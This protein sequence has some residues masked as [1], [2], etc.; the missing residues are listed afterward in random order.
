MKPNTFITILFL[1][2]MSAVMAKGQCPTATAGGSSTICELDA[3]TVSGATAADGTISWTHNGD[4][5]LSGGT[6]LTPAY[7]SVAADAGKTITL[8]LTVSKGGCADAIA[9][10]TVNV[11][12]KPSAT[13]G[14]TQTICVMGSATVSGATSGNGSIMW[15]EN[16]DGTLTGETTL[17]P[18]YTSVASDAGKTVVLTMTVSNSPCPAATATYSVIVIGT[19]S[20]SAGGSTTICE[21]GTATVSGASAANGAILW[22]EDGYGSLFGQTTLTPVYTPAAGDAGKTVT[23]TMTVSNG[24]CT[25]ATASYS[26]AV[27]AAPV[28]TAGGITAI[29]EGGTATVSGATASNG[30]ILWGTSGAGTLTG[31]TT[32]SPSYTPA[33]GESAVTLTMTVTNAYCSSASADF[34]INVHPLPALAAVSMAGHVCD[35]SKGTVQLTGLLSNS[36]FT[37]N[38]SYSDH[39]NQTAV[40]TT[41]AGETSKS[42]LTSVNLD[43]G[44]DNGDDLIINSLTITSSIPACSMNF[45]SPTYVATLQVDEIPTLGTIDLDS[46]VCEGSSATVTLNGMLP[47]V[48]SIVRYTI[49]GTVYEHSVTAPGGSITFE[50]EP[51]LSE[52]NGGEFYITQVKT[53]T[54]AQCYRDYTT[55]KYHSITVNSLPAP[56]VSGP[57]TACA[58]SAGNSYST[59]SSMTNYSWEITGGTITSAKDIRNITV[60]WGAGATGTLAVSTT[61]NSC[62]GTSPVHS[63]TLNAN[64]G[65]IISGNTSACLNSTGN[66]YSIQNGM[67]SYS[68]S[69]SAGGTITSATDGSSIAVTWN[70]AGA[71]TVSVNYT[72]PTGCSATQVHNVMVNALPVPAI[73]PSV[74]V[75]RIND[76]VTY[77]TGGNSTW[78]WLVSSGGSGTSSTNTININWNSTGPQTV[79]VN[80]LDANNC[81]ATL[82]TKLDVDVKPLPSVSGLTVSYTYPSAGTTMEAVYTY[83]DGVS[84]T[85][86]CTGCT[87]QWFSDA[88]TIPGATAKTYIP[89]LTD[90][91]KTLTVRVTPVSTVG[92]SPPYTGSSVISSPTEIIEDLSAGVPVASQ[93]CIEGIRQEGSLL[94]GKYIYTHVMPEGHSLYK[95]I[96]TDMTEPTLP[97]VTEVGWGK[98]Y[99]LT[100]DD[101][102]EGVE[103]SFSV[104]PVSTNKTP[105]EGIWTSSVDMARI[106]NL[107]AE[108]SITDDDVPLIANVTG[109]TF[110]GPGVSGSTASGYTFSPA[111][112]KDGIHT[113]NYI[114]FYDF[115]SD[116]TCAQRAPYMI[117]V[118]PDIPVLSAVNPN[119]CSDGGSFTVNVTNIKT[120][121]SGNDFILKAPDGSIYPDLL[122]TQYLDPDNM[123]PSR[124]DWIT[125]DPAVLT[126]GDQQLVYTYRIKREITFLM[127][128]L[129][130]PRTMT[131]YLTYSRD[132]SFYVDKVSTEMKILGLEGAYCVNA[133]PQYLS[134]EGVYPLGGTGTWTST[135]IVP[136]PDN[137]SAYIDPVRGVPG[138][139]YALTYQY[140][141]PRH[142]FSQVI[143]KTITVKSLPDPSFSV[144]LTFNITGEPVRML[145]ATGGGVFRGKGVSGDLF[146]PSVA[147]VGPHTITYVA[148]AN[149]CVDSSKITVKV[150]AALGSFTGI[151]DTVC[152]R[153]ANLNISMV[154]L[155]VNGTDGVISYSGFSNSKK[156]LVKVPGSK[157]TVY[158]ITAAGEGNDT[159][160]YSYV[161]DGVDYKINKIITIDSV[162]TAIIYNLSQNQI[163]CDDVAPFELTLSKP[164]GVFDA[165]SP[166]FGGYFDPSKATM[167]DTVKYTFTSRAGCSVDTLIYVNV[168]K[169]PQV[170]FIP[171]DLCIEDDRDKLMFMNK[172]TSVSPVVKWQWE[173][174]DEGKMTTDSLEES[175]YLYLKGGLQQIALTAETDKG[176][177]VRKEKTINIGRKPEAD[178]YWKKDCYYPNESLLLL[179]ATK[180]STPPKSYSWKSGGREFGTSNN[181]ALQKTDT[182][183]V[184][185]EFIVRTDYF[186]CHDTVVK[187]VYIRPTIKIPAD[188]YSQDFE[189]GKGGWIKG[190]TS[191]IWSF[192]VPDGQDI[193]SAA[194][195][196][197]AWYTARPKD[198]SSSVESPCFDLSSTSRPSFKLKIWKDFNK[199]RDGVVLQY[200]IGDDTEWRNVGRTLDDGIQWYNSTAIS[201]KP[202]GSQL[203]WTTAG[204]SDDKYLT[205]IH[206]LD[207][208]KGKKDVRFR[209]AYGSSGSYSERD[210]FA[211]DDIFIGERSRQVLMEHF[212]SYQDAVSTRYKPLV[213]TIANH[214]EGDVINIQYHSDIAGTDSLFVHN[215]GE[216]N[217]RTLYYGLTKVPYTFIDGGSGEN[218]AAIFDYRLSVID[219]N[220]I[221]KRSLMNS[222]FRLF[223]DPVISGRVLNIK[224]YIRAIENFQAENLTLFLTVTEKINAGNFEGVN[225]P[226][227][228]INVF[229][230]FI[231]DAGGIIL[232]PKW[233]VGDSIAL[234]EKSWII[235]K[236]LNS[237]DIEIIAFVQNTT[238]Q[239]VH[240][241]FSV[242]KP[243]ITTGVEDALLREGRFSMYPNPAS[244]RITVGFPD[245]LRSEADIRIYNFQGELIREYRAGA[246]LP[247][248]T[249]EDP[250]LKAGIYLV[251]V[252]RGI[253]DLGYRKLIITED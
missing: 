177:I 141:S 40:I 117:T 14:G 199:E 144:D 122:T 171:Y 10:Y 170:D 135:L 133:G 63:V 69:V 39:L 248:F 159:L 110:S 90:A 210:G 88:V 43:A 36:T 205:A 20:A 208:L 115:S 246:G 217:A 160:T 24:S 22:T 59:V 206:T 68:W 182:G 149:S 147:G 175:G 61:K 139:S 46:P 75:P 4:G 30:T 54:G 142:C 111:E 129:M 156:T 12:A 229:R 15:T 114:L 99:I 155:P 72:T 164:G 52:N 152:Y 11:T 212:T 77:T 51:L 168:Y 79:K 109:G 239:E 55:S 127:P 19:P 183:F 201:G 200:R 103:I 118:D 9:A 116:H 136:T 146:I 192:G 181:A 209:F 128:P 106:K 65:Y 78:S 84:P 37:V 34:T 35:G 174:F 125:I 253:L 123:N 45:G 67:I 222:P 176:C 119:Y 202:G 197:H 131:Y 178:F 76:A 18:V 27:M 219:S 62:T 50:S 121:S 6:T 130:I 92:V 108:Y 124:T 102:A 132:V 214:L 167:S 250:G 100:A 2:M 169:A 23:L 223:I 187:N 70:T 94:K 173:F 41:L 179:D 47:D 230:K 215:P 240:Q 227:T 26:I 184:K 195:G 165:H 66:V 234:P 211:F 189:S 161:W 213:D 153:K 198:G 143:P 137:L 73:T 249:I 48:L 247:E 226:E 231:P 191:T 107:K 101:L 32:S 60:T 3:V 97:V 13:A 81:T 180:F 71:R 150:R 157:T 196:Q 98:D 241:A 113:V 33:A 228:F 44:D 140:E 80:Y 243:D 233:I 82:P 221:T 172:T 53:S 194:S 7:T 238:T 216:I 134:V 49:D 104:R 31:Q 237:S 29:C 8:T 148:K 38:Y 57:V 93:V 56:V 105:I 242:I 252:S 42:F 64:P 145:P 120:G 58:G 91:G 87:Y 225:A 1:L 126:P 83:N 5:T 17:T 151:T 203:G 188:G 244:N 193:K 251:R 96:R 86:V 207:E 112:A 163:L 138:T 190:D 74:A 235:D 245:P 220:V 154:D 224:G 16:G 85:T 95:W 236:A 204:A 162:G 158:S 89:L 25:D 21:T 28:A 186:N 218:H 166:V 232:K 185:I